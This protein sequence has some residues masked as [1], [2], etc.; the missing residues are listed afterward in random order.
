MEINE[1]SDSVWLNCRQLMQ[2]LEISR[3]TLYNWLKTG[4]F[5]R[6]VKLGPNSNRWH[7]ADI[8]EWEEKHRKGAA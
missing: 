4:D 2:R 1:Q 8:R 3:S 7:V 5:P 6:P